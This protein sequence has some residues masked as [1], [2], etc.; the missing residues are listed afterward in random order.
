MDYSINFTQTGTYNIWLRAYATGGDDD[1]YQAGVDG[2]R[3]TDHM[4]G[5]F[6][7]NAWG[8]ILNNETTSTPSQI[9]I[10]TTG[11]HTFNIWLREDGARLEQKF[12]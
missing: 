3:T 5:P 1:S 4:A 2:L 9:T 12:P 6:P 7:Y 8:W 11:I 10:T